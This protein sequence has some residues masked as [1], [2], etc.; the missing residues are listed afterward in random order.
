[1]Y[2]LTKKI[3][4]SIFLLFSLIIHGQDDLPM[5]KNLTQAIEKGTRTNEGIPGKKYWQNTASYVIETE[6]IPKDRKLIGSEEIKYTNNSPDSLHQIIFH[7]FQNLYKK[8]SQRDISVNPNDVH[9]GIIIKN[10]NVNNKS[11][12]DFIISGTQ[13]IINLKKPI[14]PLSS[15]DITLS[16]SFLIPT[17]SDIRMGGKDESS[18][19]LGQW[20]PKIAVYDDVKKWD[21]NMHTGNQEFYSDLGDYTYTVKVPKGYIVWGTGILQNAQDVLSKRVYEKYMKAQTSGEIVSII[22]ADD[23]QS[24]KKLTQNSV[25]KFK[26]N[27][28]ADVAFGISDHFLWDGTS[29]NGETNNSVF[30]ETAYPVKAKDFKK[31]AHLA[32]KSIQYFST[33]LPGYPFPF[34]AMTI[35]NGTNGTSGMEYPMIAN[36]P[37]ASKRGRTVDV[38]AH[39]IAHNYFPFYV[40]TNE[41][42]HA[43]MDESFAAMIPYEY[44]LENDPSLNRLTRS[45]KNMSMYGNTN[46]NIAS[47]TSSTMLKGGVSYFNFYMKPAVGLYVLQDMLGKEM[48]KKCLINYIDTWKGKHPVQTDFFYSVNRTTNKNLNW[49]WKPWFYENAY[50]DIGIN[51][52]DKKDNGY[53]ITIKKIGKLPIPL[54]LTITFENQQ[55]KIIKYSAEIWKNK[56][57]IVIPITTNQKIQKIKLGNNY[58]PDVNQLDNSRVVK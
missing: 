51:N 18:F 55:T 52:I 42:E 9:S 22:D 50:P 2:N 16:W 19:F 3:A 21:K 13:L 4:P 31:V 25:W 47:A 37:S 58:I 15:V 6:I 43:W 45:V 30:I 26:A 40:L 36:D 34:P 46:R 49:F 33:K 11:I 12:T 48:F 54:Y 57:Q 27:N 29:L 39:E 28:I 24:G 20:Y 1:M 44:Q 10:L 23:Y 7:L 38:T 5:D 41:T 53:E 14:A 17:K 56:T 35:F 32:K 8:G